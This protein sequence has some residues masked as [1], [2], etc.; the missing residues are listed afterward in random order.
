MSDEISTKTPIPISGKIRFRSLV[1]GLIFLP[2]AAHGAAVPSDP[3]M[4]DPATVFLLRFDEREVRAEGVTKETFYAEL[5]TPKPAY[6]VVS[7][8]PGRFGQAMDTSLSGRLAL[9][10]RQ[11]DQPVDAFTVDLW[12]YGNPSGDGGEEV[13]YEF[14]GMHLLRATRGHRVKL[15]WDV[16]VDGVWR[17]VEGEI[18]ATGWAHVGMV[19]DG[20]TAALWIDGKRVSSAE[21]R[22]EIRRMNLW[23]RKASIG[24]DAEGGRQFKGRVD[25]FRFSKVARTDFRSA[26]VEPP[27]TTRATLKPTEPIFLKDRDG[28]NEPVRLYSKLEIPKLTQAAGIDV[29]TDDKAWSRVPA[30][31]FLET[32]I[33]FGHSRNWEAVGTVGFKLAYDSSNLYVLARVIESTPRWL[34]P[35]GPDFWQSNAL[36]IFLQPGG[37]LTPYYQIALSPYGKN[38]AAKFTLWNP[39]ASPHDRDKEELSL[40]GLRQQTARGKD[41]WTIK[42]AIPFKDLGIPAPRSGTSWRGNV[43][44]TTAEPMQQS[45]SWAYVWPLFYWDYRFGRFDFTDGQ[46]PPPERHTVKGRLVDETGAP[47]VWGT[48]KLAAF[49][50]KGR[51]VRTNSGGEFTITGVPSGPFMMRSLIS[52]HD[53]VEVSFEVKNP[54]EIL[55]P[56]VLHPIRLYTSGLPAAGHAEVTLFRASVEQPPALPVGPDS[57]TA[58]GS[59]DFVIPPGERESQAF[60]L[61]AHKEMPDL[62]VVI[63]PVFRSGDKELTVDPPLVRWTRRVIVRDADNSTHEES[64]VVWRFLDPAA[65]KSV[66]AGDMRHIVATIQVPEKAAPGQ[67]AGTLH[68]L[69]G[70]RKLAT[71]PVSLKVPPLHLAQPDKYVGF[72]HY[73]KVNGKP[74]SDEELLRDYRHMRDLGATQV[75]P[76]DVNFLPGQADPYAEI[77]R[78]IRLQIQAGMGPFYHVYPYPN[79]GQ[80][81][82]SKDPTQQTAIKELIKGLDGVEKELGLKPG[83]IMISFGDEVQAHGQIFEN[84]AEW[85]TRLKTLTDR[86]NYMSVTNTERADDRERYLRMLPLLDIANFNGTP[87]DWERIGAELK[88]HNITGW[89]YPNTVHDTMY[90][91]IANGYFLWPSPFA[92]SVPWTFYYEPKGN[93]FDSLTSEFT[94]FAYKVPDPDRPGEMLTTLMGEAYRAG[95]DDLRYLTTLEKALKKVP[96]EKRETDAFRKATTLLESFRKRPEI[97]RVHGDSM[98]YSADELN[99]R[100]RQ[101]AGAIEALQTG[102]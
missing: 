20:K 61:A 30:E 56:I 49:D 17:T 53:P 97:S 102:E 10:V 19:F 26:P 96:P 15:A 79:P 46:S 22:G 13:V 84:W 82:V 95:Y 85:S 101:I 6:P 71:L 29:L 64:S 16:R 75:V 87:H 57:L 38:W 9:H 62:R 67:Y 73:T 94:I 100:R 31:W 1:A 18:P 35:Q 42:A 4:V 39:R 41:S 59:L 45:H 92:A 7:L 23:H 70:D 34:K 33:G 89:F 24:R 48:D 8:A 88:K 98:P 28:N 65:P 90:A 60:A 12:V 47:V 36:E 86:P 50:W 91:R 14:P 32:T 78:H 83:Q 52:T 25:E 63:D 44:Y 27:P 11:V 58:A 55:E 37:A 5:L 66:A 51:P 76:A 54:V 81:L 40:P 2:L 80:Q 77:K 43:A 99:Q 69:S 3:V 74:L 21:T 93:Y 68:I 72:Y